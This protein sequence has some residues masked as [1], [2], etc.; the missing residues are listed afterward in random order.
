MYGVQIPRELKFMQ[1]DWKSM[2]YKRVKI[3]G[4]WKWIPEK[5]K[6]DS[7]NTKL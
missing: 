1:M 6:E 3:D 4:V 7:E 2:G 5:G